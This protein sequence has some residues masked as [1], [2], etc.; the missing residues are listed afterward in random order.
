MLSNPTFSFRHFASFMQSQPARSLLRSSIVHQ[1][2]NDRLIESARDAFTAKK[3][4]AA[5]KVFLSFP[6]HITFVDLPCAPASFLTAGFS[7]SAS[8]RRLPRWLF[9]RTRSCC[10]G[11]ILSICHY[12]PTL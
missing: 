9:S 2:H 1:L 10:A 3:F 6:L 12:A 11:P 8:S 5:L 7:V 4:D